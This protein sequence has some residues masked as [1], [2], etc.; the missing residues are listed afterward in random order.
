MAY[1]PPAE[2]IIYI[3]QYVYL[4]DDLRLENGDDIPSF[5]NGLR[6]PF[7][8]LKLDNQIVFLSA[9][10]V[11]QSGFHLYVDASGPA[12]FSNAEESQWRAGKAQ[13]LLES[14]QT[15]K[16]GP[17]ETIM[18]MRTC[19]HLCG[20][21]IGQLISNLESNRKLPGESLSDI[22]LRIKPSI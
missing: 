10:E 22:F 1:G 2:Y 11:F 15:T 20:I 12:W 17:I 8:R 19:A 13:G 18:T 21:N 16:L 6:L 3:P 9:P 4:D 7:D 5:D 14:I